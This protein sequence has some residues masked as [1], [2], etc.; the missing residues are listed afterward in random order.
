VEEILE[1]PL[2]L[3]ARPGAHRTETWE[4]FGMTHEVHFFSLGRD[5]IWGATA[6]VLSELLAIWRAP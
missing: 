1:V 4:A 3:L 6:R 2:D 5:T